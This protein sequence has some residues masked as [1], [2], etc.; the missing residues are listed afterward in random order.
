MA[1]TK[2]GD[3]FHASTRFM[4]SVH[5]ERDFDD[6]SALQS[7]VVTPLAKAHL[8]RLSSGLVA[9]SKQRAWRLTGDY[10]SGKSSFALVAA[11]ALSGRSQLSA[12]IRALVDFKQIGL[13][14]RPELLP[15]L[16]TGSREPISVALL[17]SVQRALESLSTKGG[18]SSILKKINARLEPAPR[19]EPSDEEVIGILDG[20]NQYLHLSEKGSGLLLIIDELG[21]FL[22][23]A[24]MNPE[25]QD[26]FFLQRLAEA[27]ARSGKQQMLVVGILHQGFNA[28]SEHLSPAAQREWE[29]V[30]GRFEE[31]LFHP[32][33]E[34]SVALLAEA[35]GVRKDV[36]PRRVHERARTAME[37]ALRLN[38]Y[39]PGVSQQTLTETAAALY[40]LHPTVV[41]VLV[42]FLSRFGQNERSLFSFL[43]SNEPFGLMSF[44][45]QPATASNWF[46]LD[47]LYDYVRSSF[48]HRLSVQSY[49]SQWNKIESLI[50]SFA[51]ENIL[52]LRILK[53]VGVLNLL[54]S[55][56]LTANEKTLALALWS[57]ETSGKQI[58]AALASLRKRQVLYSRGVAGGF[59]LWPHSSVNLEL[60]YE[61]ARKS[62]GTP[63]RIAPL[64]SKQFET[65][66]LVARRHYIQTGNLRYFEILYRAVGDV[67]PVQRNGNETPDGHIVV[68]LC[69]S[70]EEHA[71]AVR[72]ARGDVFRLPNILVA[73]PKPLQGLSGLVLEAMRWK[74]VVEN[75]KE[76][77]SDTYA[78]AE[79]SRHVASAERVRDARLQEF[80]GL[81]QFTG[82]TELE[83]FREAKRV[84]IS[85]AR[86]LLE[87]LSIICD[88][89]FHQ[90]PAIKNE[91]VNRRELSSAAA[92]ARMRLIERLFDSSTKPFLGLDEAK[93]PPEMSM[94]LSV[95]LASGVHREDGDV[96]KIVVPSAK[97]DP[98][99]LRP[100]LDHLLDVLRKQNDRKIKVSDL[101]ATLH[102]PPFGVRDGLGFLLLAVFVQVYNSELALYEEGVFLRELSG[103]VMQRLVKR[104]EMFEL[105]YCRI[106]GVRNV[107]FEQLVRALLPDRVLKG[108]PDVLDVVRPLCTFAANL[109]AYAQ[110]T[111]RVSAMARAV[112]GVLTAAKEPAPLLFDELPRACGF[113][114]FP[115]TGRAAD[116][117]RVEEFVAAL[118]G[119]CD[120]LKRAYP[121]LIEQI[122]ATLGIAFERG[123]NVRASLR[124]SAEP[125]LQAVAEPALRTLCLRFLDDALDDSEW[126]ESIGGLICHK[127]PSK[128]T[129]ADSEHF[130]EQL[131]ELARR[132]KH[133]ESM[134][135]PAGNVT[136]TALRLAITRAD[137]SQ[138][139]QVLRVSAEE[140]TLV[141]SLESEF[142]PLLRRKDQR[143]AL[144]AAARAV[145]K[146]LSRYEE[147]N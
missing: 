35:L 97:S 103:P 32:P 100:T 110:K 54:D 57:E 106:S 67:R 86:D 55:D 69:E 72:H 119:S 2:I 7:Y 38:W 94:Y 91:L 33:L 101:L 113:K 96:H 37:E 52:E 68:F 51:T 104:P 129:D 139:E 45:G 127:P 49:R 31:L 135:F 147:K 4:R 73:V 53:A 40:P 78:A 1:A 23:F 61:N 13:T 123:G 36:L 39:G 74:W 19:K 90:A 29:K 76:L 130:A 79:V 99:K 92:A 105:Q 118:R 112:R 75:T 63:Q 87:Q 82:L 134:R 30:A 64:L 21:K 20:V 137:G 43:F 66:P 140:E 120:E 70:D 85:G 12:K 71:V 47:S 89:V 138:L 122:K 84:S 10:G 111:Q 98:C 143:L 34:Q 80:L 58:E 16:V 109:P 8:E 60:A 5:L 77:N 146:E 117:E 56:G 41:P 28:Y 59:C 42:R 83:W 144:A 114:P 116:K 17:R 3:V 121:G 125:I 133:V 126:Y 27:A 22:E 142:L 11:H 128:W 88:E 81:K 107:L 50:S 141:S 26:I 18:P 62:I 25:R 15:V 14:R 93:A 115:A 24:A 95:L 6:A 44:A 65:R 48:G 108:Q 9:D 145:W 132:F 131:G 46:R 102:A 136:A 124:S